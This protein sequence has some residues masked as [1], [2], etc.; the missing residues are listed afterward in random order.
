MPGIALNLIN[1]PSKQTCGSVFVCF[2]E[3][4]KKGIVGCA[5]WRLTDCL[6][7]LG[8]DVNVLIPK[9]LFF[10]VIFSRLSTNS[11]SDRNFLAEIISLPEN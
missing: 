2:N 7:R 11:T 6:K 8:F 3:E 1:V 4:I 5:V 10:L 9:L